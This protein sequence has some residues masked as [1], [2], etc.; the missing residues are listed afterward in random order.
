[1]SVQNVFNRKTAVLLL[2]IF[3][4]LLAISPAGMR[5]ATT[6]SPREVASDV[7]NRSDHITAEELAAL[8]ID[9]DPNLLIVD[10]R[11][12]EEYNQFHIE[13]AI[14]IPLSQL[15]EQ[16]SLD[17]LS[18]DYNIVVYSN[19]GTHSAQAWV[20]LKE[21]GINCYTLL[22][23]L[24]YWAEAIMNPEPPDDLAADSEILQYQFRK[25]ASGYFN[26]GTTIE[27]ETKESNTPPPAPKRTFKRKKKSGDEGC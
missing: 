19:G 13:G 23:G 27:Q 17:M 12:A 21:M 10:L 8:I 9:K 26:N 4:A 7:I 5:K 20:L 3:G 24:N 14:N 1:M 11:S 18:P 16:E 6:L 22:G 15:F 2:L 25:S